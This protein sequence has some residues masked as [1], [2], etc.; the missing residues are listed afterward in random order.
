M[1]PHNLHYM[2]IM[3][4]IAGYRV[5]TIQCPDDPEPSVLLTKRASIDTSK[6]IYAYRLS[7]TVLIERN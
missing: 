2:N 7:D 3:F 6:I 1:I 5:F 4:A